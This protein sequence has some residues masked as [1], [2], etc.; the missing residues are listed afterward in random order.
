MPTPIQ[1][2]NST[3]GDLP[4]EGQ[5]KRRNIP[6]SSDERA[7]NDGM[8]SQVAIEMERCGDK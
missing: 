5:S 6:T 3:H 1:T 8:R 4:S 2:D 7:S